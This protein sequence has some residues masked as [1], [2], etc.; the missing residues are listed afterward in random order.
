MEIAEDVFESFKHDEV[1]IPGVI[2]HRCKRWF[3]DQSFRSFLPT[4]TSLLKFFHVMLYQLSHFS[5][6]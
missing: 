5:F 2:R 3:R 6:K 1:E 4:A